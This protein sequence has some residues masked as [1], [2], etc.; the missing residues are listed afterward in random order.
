LQDF[1]FK[2]DKYSSSLQSKTVVSS[3]MSIS[4][5]IFRYHSHTISLMLS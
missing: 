5:H 2:V 4:K 3:M 1:H